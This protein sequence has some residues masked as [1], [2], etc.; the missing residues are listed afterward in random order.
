MYGV[1]MSKPGGQEYYDSIVKLYAGWG[2]DYIK[3]DD[4]AIPSHGAEIEALHKAIVKS[5]RPIVLSL[6][7]GPADISQGRFLRR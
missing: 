4:M 6:S 1:D 5:G 7:P 2:V 3:A